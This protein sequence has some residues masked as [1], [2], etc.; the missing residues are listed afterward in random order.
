ML[1]GSATTNIGLSHD[2]LLVL[3]VCAGADAD[4]DVVVVVANVDINVVVVAGAG[5]DAGINIDNDVDGGC[6][7]DSFGPCM[8]QVLVHS[9]CV[10]VCERG[11]E[12]FLVGI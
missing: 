2:D 11:I 12:R 1:R 8:S 10:C 6:A 7:C 9:L 3:V 5:A 4:A